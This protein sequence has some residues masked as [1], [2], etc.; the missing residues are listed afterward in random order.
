MR[1]LMTDAIQTS[2]DAIGE[3]TALSLEI[4]SDL[5]LGRT[6]IES[7]CLKA[8]RLARLLND[9]QAQKA[10]EYEVNEYPSG[11]DGVPADVYQL[12]RWS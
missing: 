1:D 6:T 3:A 9:S 8:S 2:A 5:E 11:P 4:L 7:L 10:F 12:C